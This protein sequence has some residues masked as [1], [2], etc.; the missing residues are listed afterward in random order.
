MTALNVKSLL[1]SRTYFPPQVGGISHF[2]ASVGAALGSQR[3]CCLTGVSC[4]G[5]LK[6]IAGVKIYRRP[7]AFAE[8]NIQA[9]SWSI[10]I[11]Q[12]MMQQRPQAV[13]LAT[14]SEGYLGLWMRKWLKLPFVIYAHGNEV[15]AAMRDDWQKPRLAL[16]QANRVLANSRFTADL[17]EK[18]GVHPKRIEI[19]H[20]GCET[21]H[22]RPLEPNIDLRKK[23]F[24]ARQK[25][26]VLLTVGG[27]VARKG[28]DMVIRALP[29]VLQRIPNVL[30]LIVGDGRDRAR[31]EALTSATGVQD[32]VIFAGQVPD[33]DLPDIYA[34][35]DVFVMPSRSRLEDCDVEGF[36]LVYLEANACGKPVIGGREGGVAD[37][38]LEGE[39][40]FL[41]DP[42]D[43]DHIAHLLLRLLSD[44][45]LSRRMGEKGRKRVVSDFTW[46]RVSSHVQGTI[47]AIVQEQIDSLSQV[48]PAQSA[49]DR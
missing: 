38:I 18:I 26:R 12:I 39:T 40:G 43:S 33:S 45:E 17:V 46:T 24:G 25:D 35:S 20:P 11:S 37:A 36:G 6:D 8:G 23:L 7:K 10:A 4:N 9:L 47:E 28:Q 30:Y 41:A 31:L 44:D 16:Q 22:F 42:C 27:L 32:R 19:L 49:A 15:L 48:T 5:S 2:M 29:K 21:S 3:V 13:Q 34:L 14:A 1:I